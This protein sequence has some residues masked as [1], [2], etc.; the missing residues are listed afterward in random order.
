LFANRG[1]WGGIDM[2]EAQLEAKTRGNRISDVVLFRF[3]SR[4]FSL[5]Y[6]FYV[7]LRRDGNGRSSSEW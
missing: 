7:I 4:S 3:G 2:I 6:T 5:P 1:A